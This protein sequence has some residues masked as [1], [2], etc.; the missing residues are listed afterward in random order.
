MIDKSRKESPLPATFQGPNPGDFPLG[1]MESRAAA[2]A[3]VRSSDTTPPSNV[4]DGTL[5]CSKC[6]LSNL[7]IPPPDKP[8]AHWDTS[9][10]CYKNLHYSPEEHAALGLS[11]SG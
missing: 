10:G 6:C 11:M 8:D 5:R 7:P 3:I 2:R 4:R 9:R 1:S